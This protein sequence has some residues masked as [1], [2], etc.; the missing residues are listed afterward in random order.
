MTE[1][2]YQDES[3]T[4]YHGDCREI[5]PNLQKVD[6]VVTDPPY[7]NGADYFCEGVDATLD[8]LRMP[9]CDHVIAFWDEL[10]TPYCAL[11]LVA[12]HIWFRTNTNRPDNYE[13]IY[14]WRA[15][16]RK[17]ASKVFPYAVIAVGL[18]GCT[19]ATGHPTQKHEVLMESLTRRTVGLVADPFMGSGTT[20]RAAK[21]LGRKAIGIEIEEKYCEIA[22][23]RCEQEV[24][25]LQTPEELKL[26]QELFE[27]PSSDYRIS[28][29]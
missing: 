25:P 27:F 12:K 10:E 11:P 1:P 22:A 28:Q 21:N 18:T 24:L 23:K 8:V 9:M 2:Y 17:R 5:L 14:E 7:P 20:L 29:P 16:G 26:S 13:A 15:D 6:A 4:I 3:V 19:Q